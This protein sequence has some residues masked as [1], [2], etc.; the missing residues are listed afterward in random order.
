MANYK[1]LVSFSGAISM[2]KDEVRALDDEAL[3]KDLLEAGYIE[4]V[5]SEEEK[6]KKKGTKK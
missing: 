6:P 3:C 1:A 2:A 5:P 4:E